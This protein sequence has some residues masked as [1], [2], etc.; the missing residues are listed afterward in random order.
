[1]LFKDLFGPIMS[2]CLSAALCTTPTVECE[3]E[4]SPVPTEVPSTE[5]EVIVYEEIPDDFSIQEDPHIDINYEE[6]EM[7]ARLAWGEARGIESYAEK[8]AIMWIPL[9]RMSD[10]RWP[11]D[12]YTVLNQKGQFYYSDSFPV[13]DDLYCVACHVL[14][15]YELEKLG[16]EADRVIPNDYFY[17]TGDG[18]HN[19]FR[20]EYYSTSYWDWSYE[21][22]YADWVW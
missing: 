19:H 5:V 8:A 11:D 16:Y 21:D 20:K 15:Q 12:L 7:L 13:L 14:E 22:V 2:L 17:Y 4:P 1:M 9:N 3:K 10:E 6:A 18:E